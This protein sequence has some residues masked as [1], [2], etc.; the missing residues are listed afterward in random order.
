MNKF[1]I[2]A[3]VT[4][5]LAACS[6]S[7]PDTGAAGQGAPNKAPAPKGYADSAG[8]AG[9][10]RLHD[11]VTFASAKTTNR[12]S[13]DR[14]DGQK[15]VKGQPITAVLGK[16]LVINGWAADPQKRTPDRFLIVLR[17]PHGTYATN[18]T[19]GRHRPDVAA[20]L[21]SELLANA[22]FVSKKPLDV[23]VPGEYSVALLEFVDGEY[24]TCASSARLSV[25]Q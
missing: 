25:V 16:D 15:P 22:G 20:A 7:K 14:I 11:A 6:G 19:A 23:V 2:C 4:L 24:S 9:W 8:E 13:I 10:F 17:S 5:L 18:A 12:C 21:N 1:L 3:G